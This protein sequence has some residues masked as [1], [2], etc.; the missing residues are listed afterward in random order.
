MI[1]KI[2]FV[3]IAFAAVGI[4]AL[5]L[6]QQSKGDTGSAFGGGG[7][8]SLFGSRGSAN[9]LSRLT[10]V[11]VTVFFSASI[12]LAYVYS[13]QTGDYANTPVEQEDSVLNALESLN[14]EVPAAP[15]ASVPSL[16]NNEP[17]L[18]VPAAPST[19]PQS[20]SEV[21]AVETEVPVVPAK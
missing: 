12:G 8:Q 18:E 5:V 1:A 9:F 15:D 11:F 2:L 6:I 19:A 16:P 14:S 17:S 20:Q 3:V 21:P 7:S 10:S 4:V 13:K